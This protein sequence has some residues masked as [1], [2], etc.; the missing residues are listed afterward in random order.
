VWFAVMMAGCPETSHSTV[1]TLAREI[2][3]RGIPTIIISASPAATES[4]RPPRP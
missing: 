4:I 1:G 3:V 2:E